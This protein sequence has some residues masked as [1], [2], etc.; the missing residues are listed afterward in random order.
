MK[1]KSCMNINLDKLN[2]FV[3][4][5]REDPDKGRFT[6]RTETAWQ[7]G[8]VSRTRARKFEIETDEP[9]PLGGMDSAIDP[10]ELLLASVGSCMALGFATQAA[11]HEMEIKDFRIETEGD[12][13]VRG[14]LGLPGGRPGFNNI[15]YTLKVD[16]EATE[17]DLNKIMRLAESSSP[18]VDNILN[19]VNIES[20][21]QKV[22]NL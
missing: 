22:E 17:D 8:S 16:T 13:D 12:I 15:R 6:F 10:V 5:V 7:D 2:D 9:E 1:T 4:T 20:R 3:K 11:K 14:Y 18:M 19:G 21:L